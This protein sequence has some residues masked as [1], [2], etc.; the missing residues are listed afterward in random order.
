MPLTLTRATD[1]VDLR[2]TTADALEHARAS[3]WHIRE[4][5]LVLCELAANALMHAPGPYRV[6]VVIETTC[7]IVRVSDRGA[8]TVA[9]RAPAGDEG[10]FGLHVVDA[11]APRWGSRRTRTGKTVWAELDRSRAGDCSLQSASR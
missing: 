2:A 6:E 3:E 7:T 9:K 11:L 10:G 8:G 1:L 4:V 5:L